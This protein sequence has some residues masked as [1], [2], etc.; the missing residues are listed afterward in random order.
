MQVFQRLAEASARRAQVPVEGVPGPS[1]PPDVGDQ[2]EEGPGRPRVGQVV[3]AGQGL[4]GSDLVSGRVDVI[5]RD[6][7]E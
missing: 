1:L 3:H 2:A 7:V 4:E 5:L 6:H